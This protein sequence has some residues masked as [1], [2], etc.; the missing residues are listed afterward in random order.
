MPEIKD[1]EDT[2][3]LRMGKAFKLMARRMA[4]MKPGETTLNEVT[5][6]AAWEK[7]LME[8]D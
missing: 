1:V 7:F 4:N 8:D 5:C 6:Q 2:F 3:N